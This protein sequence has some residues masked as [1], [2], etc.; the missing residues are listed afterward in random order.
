MAKDKKKKKR[1]GTKG[2][3][4]LPDLQLPM[5]GE[6]PLKASIFLRT[7]Q[8]LSLRTICCSMMQKHHHCYS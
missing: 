6:T 3:P 1:K 2:K 7:F 5:I 4:K 8:C